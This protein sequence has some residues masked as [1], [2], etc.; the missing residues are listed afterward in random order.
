[1]TRL[2]ALFWEERADLGNQGTKKPLMARSPGGKDRERAKGEAL[3]A[4][5][6][7]RDG[8][9][10]PSRV[11]VH[12]PEKAFRWHEEALTGRVCVCMCVGACKRGCGGVGKDGLCS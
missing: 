8:H 7:T 4:F 6:G 3:Q 5:V 9:L 2:S 1:M 11:R 10:C 12:R